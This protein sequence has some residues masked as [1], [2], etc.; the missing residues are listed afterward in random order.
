MVPMVS[1]QSQP[2]N[3]HQQP[4]SMRM[5]SLEEVKQILE[6]MITRNTRISA[7]WDALIE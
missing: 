7:I 5:D 3:S 6:R 2:L 4:S 1:L